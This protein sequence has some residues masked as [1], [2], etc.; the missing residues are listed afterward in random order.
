[1]IKEKK[2][3]HYRLIVKKYH[4]CT[5]YGVN[6]RGLKSLHDLDFWF[7][8]N[9]I[10][11][12]NSKV[13]DSVKIFPR[14]YFLQMHS[15]LPL[16]KCKSWL[17]LFA[18]LKCPTCTNIKKNWKSCMTWEIKEIEMNDSESVCETLFLLY[19]HWD[20]STKVSVCWRLIKN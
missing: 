7:V 15:I 19:R 12:I 14:L 13:F 10:L 9:I 8:W 4:V 11:P 5:M 3:T 18:E 17:L 2:T 1:M 20:T 16:I 6:I